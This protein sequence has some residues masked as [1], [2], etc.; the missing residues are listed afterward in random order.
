MK[1]HFVAARIPAVQRR[2]RNAAFACFVATLSVALN[3][4]VFAWSSVTRTSYPDCDVFM[5]TDCMSQEEWDV[6]CFGICD[7]VDCVSTCNS[8]EATGSCANYLTSSQ[9]HAGYLPISAGCD[10]GEVKC[11]CGCDCKEEE[12]GRQP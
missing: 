6:F 8:T 2:I 9:G 12:E 11:Q 10:S 4:G 5:N 3:L 1:V 7:A